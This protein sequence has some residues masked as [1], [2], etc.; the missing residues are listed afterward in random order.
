MQIDLGY[1]AAQAGIALA[2]QL[3]G[4]GAIGTLDATL[5]GLEAIKDIYFLF[6][7]YSAT[8][9]GGVPSFVM[10]TKNI[11]YV[12]YTLSIPAALKLRSYKA[13]ANKPADLDQSKA[14]ILHTLKSGLN[15]LDT[16]DLDSAE[17]DADDSNDWALD[18]GY[19]YY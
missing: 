5:T 12:A 16:W 8:S 11:C 2:G 14:V 1:N 3:T 15:D 10:E 18:Q 17:E 7:T 13:A 9:G 4:S 6:L 19:E